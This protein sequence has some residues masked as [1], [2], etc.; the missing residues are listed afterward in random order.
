MHDCPQNCGS[1][2][3]FTQQFVVAHL[4]CTLR[5]CMRTAL[6][7]LFLLIIGCCFFVAVIYKREGSEIEEYMCAHL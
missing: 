3:V 6:T 7:V 5:L 1:T 4:G 2:A